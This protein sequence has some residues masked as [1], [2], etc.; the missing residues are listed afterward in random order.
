[1]VFIFSILKFSFKNALTAIVAK[2][3]MQK[4]LTP[5]LQGMEQ[6]VFQFLKTLVVPVFQ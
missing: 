5:L 2:N 6:K 1:M 4:M 3:R